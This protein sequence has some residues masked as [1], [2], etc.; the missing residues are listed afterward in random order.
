MRT[1]TSKVS[2]NNASG[3]S[4]ANP[5][6]IRV[7]V[8]GGY[9]SDPS[10][11]GITFSI[12][13]Q[14]IDAKQRVIYC[15]EQE[16]DDEIEPYLRNELKMAQGISVQDKNVVDGIRD[17]HKQK[18][19]GLLNPLILRQNLDIVKKEL[20]GKLDFS[21]VQGISI[22]RL[23]SDIANALI[24]EQANTELL[25]LIQFL[26]ANNIKFGAVLDK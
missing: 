18:I 22:Q 8:I 20:E 7:V 17:K 4:T 24:K 3:T 12:T 25:K 11:H 14:L 2:T 5:P 19:E 6:H 9:H 21:N 16:S 15:F 1:D 10:L 26:I 23:C 13:K